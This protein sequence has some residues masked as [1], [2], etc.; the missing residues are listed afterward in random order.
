VVCSAARS[1]A[2]WVL[3]TTPTMRC[4]YLR[5]AAFPWEDTFDESALDI[6]WDVR[7]ACWDR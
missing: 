7:L 4:I 6:F 1:Q 3:R 5:F 2:N